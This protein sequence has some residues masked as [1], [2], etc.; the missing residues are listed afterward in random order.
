MPVNAGAGARHKQQRR[1][2]TA[3]THS[4]GVALGVAL[5]HEGPSL[6]SSDGPQIAAEAPFCAVLIND[7]LV[8][9]IFESILYHYTMDYAK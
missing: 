3:S 5:G 4:A 8:Y 7:L 1:P 2:K 9:L 6:P